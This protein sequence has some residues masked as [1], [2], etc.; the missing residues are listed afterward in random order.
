MGAMRIS[1]D[2][3]SLLALVLLIGAQDSSGQPAKLSAPMASQAAQC[4]YSPSGEFICPPTPTPSPTATPSAIPTSTPTAVPTICAYGPSGVMSCYP[5]PTA[6]PTIAPELSSGPVFLSS[7]P[8]AALVGQSLE[9]EVKARSAHPE[10]IEFALLE[11]PEGMSINLTSGLVSWTPG[12]NQLGDQQVTI[13][14]ADSLGDNTQSFTLTVF[15]S[16]VVVS[17]PISAATGGVV[18]VD[19][20]A[21]SIDGLSVEIPPGALSMDTTVSISELPESSQ[22]LGGSPY[23]FFKGF[24]IDLGEPSSTRYIATHSTK[25][26]VFTLPVSVN[27]PYRLSDFD[28]SEGIPSEEF[29]GAYLLSPLTG[30]IEGVRNAAVNSAYS[31]VSVPSIYSGVYFIKNKARLCPPPTGSGDSQRD[32]PSAY[33]P[34]TPSIQMPAILIHGFMFPWTLGNEGTW[35]QLRFLLHGL[36]DHGSERIDAW[37]FDWDSKFTDFEESAAHLALAIE[38]VKQR[39]GKD[40]VNLVAHS[41]GG[42]VVRTYLQGR[43]R[44]VAY[45]DDVNKLMTVGSPHQGIGGQFSNA[46]ADLCG[47]S[48]EKLHVQTCHEMNTGAS[49]GQDDGEFLRELNCTPIANGTP[50]PNCMPLPTL[51]AA[52]GVQYQVVRGQ[53]LHSYIRNPHDQINP[54]VWSPVEVLTGDGLINF[55]GSAL[56]T[57]NSPICSPSVNVLEEVIASDRNKPWGLCHSGVLM[58]TTCQIGPFGPEGKENVPMV[59]VDDTGHPLWQKIC[60]FLSSPDTADACEP[61]LIV[62]VSDPAAGSVTSDEVPPKI[63]C[64]TTCAANYPRNDDTTPKIAQLHHHEEPGYTFIGWSGDNGCG[65]NGQVVMDET[66]VCQANFAISHPISE[67]LDPFPDIHSSAGGY[68]GSPQHTFSLELNQPGRFDLDVDEG[69]FGGDAHGSKGNLNLRGWTYG[70]SQ[71]ALGNGSASYRETFVVISPGKAGSGVAKLTLNPALLVN[72]PDYC[73]GPFTDDRG[74]AALTVY[75]DEFSLFSLGL[76][77]CGADASYSYDLTANI[78][79]TYGVTSTFYVDANVGGVSY[80]AGP[81]CDGSTTLNYSITVPGDPDAAIT[82]CRL[83]PQTPMSPT[84]LINSA[85]EQS[86]GN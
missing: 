7:P 75:S 25:S 33:A 84:T 17:A 21:S 24:S 15:D 67:C 26:A 85:P 35:D 55:A 37:R 4:H 18:T 40:T 80:F 57:P 14:A 74:T 78:P 39:T 38:Q 41:F 42:L 30:M 50:M 11:A 54:P 47:N 51:R 69:N 81:L 36:N 77:F 20:P 23:F 86:F 9:Y 52:S 64:G 66:K 13:E 27:V 62:G 72:A 58:G 32:C 48:W 19:N 76:K 73:G 29:L 16:Q 56:C 28:T 31:F 82:Y 22:T 46:F 34:S 12:S 53:L 43:A 6:T 1:R 8:S 59:A 44:G 10:T 79:F 65:S 61:T 63:S 3:L 83:V 60:K 49:S 71:G 68:A 5:G 2:L 70:N 45:H